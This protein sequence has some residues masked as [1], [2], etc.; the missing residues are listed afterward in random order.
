[1]QLPDE[2]PEGLGSG[3]SRFRRVRGQIPCEVPESSGSEVP[4]GF[5]GQ[6]AW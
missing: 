6:D 2:V 5:G 4:K 3:G 1:V